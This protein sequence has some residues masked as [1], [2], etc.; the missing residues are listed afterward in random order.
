MGRI[1]KKI[2]ASVVVCLVASMM[3]AVPVFAVSNYFSK[4][5][6][7]LNALNGGIST[8]STLSSG[9]VS[10]TNPSISDVELYCNVSSGTDPYTLYVKS[11]EG[12]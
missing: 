2:L 4:T 9:S 7:K 6:V 8:K 3:F 11:P 12:T 10:G 1:K 5:T